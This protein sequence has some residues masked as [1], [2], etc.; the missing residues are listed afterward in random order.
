MR[1]IGLVDWILHEHTVLG[2]CFALEHSPNIEV[3]CCGNCC[4]VCGDELRPRHRVWI[5][6]FVLFATIFVSVE[7]HLEIHGSLWKFCVTT[8][9]LMP[10]TCLMK[11][12][13]TRVSIQAN[14][15]TG[16]GAVSSRYPVPPLGYVIGVEDVAL[17]L[18]GLG[19]LYH[20]FH[21][22]SDSKDVEAAL[23]LAIKS[24]ATQMILEIPS[25]VWKYFFCRFCCCCCCCWQD[26]QGDVRRLNQFHDTEEPERRAPQGD[27]CA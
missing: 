8:F 18:F 24:W 26:A 19:I 1:P 27:Q 5:F 6:F 11:S 14:E 16:L 25:L 3:P 15:R 10:T 7:S 23:L 2:L 22:G 9:V 13:I 17:A 12:M 4:C 20:L 21:E